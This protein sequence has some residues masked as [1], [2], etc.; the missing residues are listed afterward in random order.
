M[1]LI[2]SVTLFLPKYKYIKRLSKGW[3]MAQQVRSTVGLIFNT[4]RLLDACTGLYWHL[5]TLWYKYIHLGKI[6]IHIKN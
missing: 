3:E 6:S 5:D 4:Q 1:S 2:S